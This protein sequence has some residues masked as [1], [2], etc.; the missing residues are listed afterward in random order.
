M[1][2][3]AGADT[4]HAAMTT[5]LPT[6]TAAE[7]FDV[8]LS[9]NSREKPTVERIAERLKR[10][11]VEPWLDKWCLTSG[12]DWQ[13]ELAA[14]LRRS[15]A[16]AVFIGPALPDTSGLSPGRATTRKRVWLSCRSLAQSS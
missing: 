8:F 7:P 2:A 11:A 16:C 12:G 13:E 4:V 3:A 10:D 5:D 15:K 6:A 1:T 14:G 9:H